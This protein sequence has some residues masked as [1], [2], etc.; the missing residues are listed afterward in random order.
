[1]LTIITLVS[2]SKMSDNTDK[3]INVRMLE[4]QRTECDQN[5]FYYTLSKLSIKKSLRILR[6]INEFIIP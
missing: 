4:T 5:Q 3:R 2:F 1:M 6:Q